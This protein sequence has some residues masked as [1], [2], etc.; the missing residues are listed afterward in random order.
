MLSR[1]LNT[2]LE[3]GQRAALSWRSY[4]SCHHH[5][6]RAEHRGFPTLPSHVCALLYSKTHHR[7]GHVQ[8]SSDAGC[9]LPISF[10]QRKHNFLIAISAILTVEIFFKIHIHYMK[11]CSLLMTKSKE[12][13]IFPNN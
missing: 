5:P 1:A 13:P 3:V 11:T 12:N 7:A 10:F 8:H 4:K 6:Q 9:Q 2:H